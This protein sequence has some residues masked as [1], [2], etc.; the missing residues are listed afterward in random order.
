ML[1]ESSFFPPTEL[2]LLLN[3]SRDTALTHTYFNIEEL[4]RYRH[5]LFLAS[6]LKVDAVFATCDNIESPSTYCR[7]NWKREAKFGPLTCIEK[8]RYIA[9]CGV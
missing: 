8:F 7:S 4:P 1:S 5:L 6:F 2:K 3:V 9:F